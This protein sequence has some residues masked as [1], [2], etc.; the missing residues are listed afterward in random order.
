[1][2]KKRKASPKTKAASVS[3]RRRRTPSRRGSATSTRLAG[4]FVL[5][6]IISCILL[7]GLAFLGLSGYQTATAS[8][9]FGLRNIEIKGN[10]RTPAEDIRRVVAAS[11]EKPGVWNADLA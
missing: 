9:F 6:A 4:R 10:E 5:P 11:A 7:A 2:A 3:V 1:M 8:D